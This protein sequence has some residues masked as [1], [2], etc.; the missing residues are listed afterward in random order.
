MSI[1]ES[2]SWPVFG[3]LLAAPPWRE[4]TE[5]APAASA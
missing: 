2:A 4:H 1:V 5:D 3:S